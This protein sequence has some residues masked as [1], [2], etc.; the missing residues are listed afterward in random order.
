MGGGK[1]EGNIYMKYFFSEKWQKFKITFEI[2]LLELHF[3][4]SPILTY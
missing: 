4:F 1:L 3:S 2:L